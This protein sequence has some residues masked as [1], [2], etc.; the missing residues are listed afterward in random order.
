[1]HGGTP[2]YFLYYLLLA[3]I[4]ASPAVQASTVALQGGLLP[5]TCQLDAVD[6]VRMPD[7]HL[8]DIQAVVDG[9]VLESEAS[10]QLRF[11]RCVGVSGVSLTFS[12]AAVPGRSQYLNNGDA[13]GISLE[14]VDEDSNTVM[15]AGGYTRVA[16]V[17]S[18]DAVHFSGKAYYFRLGSDPIGGNVVDVRAMVSITYQ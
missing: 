5:G 12:G 10:F 6:E 8:R 16:P 1:M 14:L 2:A 18:G 7:V 11:E 9:R 13:S 17:G 15:P 4:T 3:A